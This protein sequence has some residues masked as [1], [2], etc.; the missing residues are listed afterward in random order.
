MRRR[1]LSRA[2]RCCWRSVAAIA[3]PRRRPSHAD[4]DSFPDVVDHFKYGS[5][6]TEEGVGLPYWIWQVLPTVF[7]DKLP[8]RPGT[9]YERLGFVLDRRGT[10]GRSARPTSRGP[11]RARRPQLRHLSRRHVRETPR[12]PRRIVAGMPANQ[13][14]LQGYANFLT[15]CASDPRFNYDTLMTA[16]RKENPD[17]G[18]FTRLIYRLFIVRATKNGIL[19]RAEQNAWFE[20]RPPF[21][22]G[23]VDTFNPYKVMLELPIDDVVGTV[24]LPSLWNQRMRAR[25]WLHWDGNNDLGRG[26]QQ[27]RRHRRRRDARLARPRLDAPDRELDSRSEAAAVP[28][29]ADRQGS[30][31]PT[32]AASGSRPAPAATRS[33]AR[34]S[35]R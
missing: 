18:W 22:P 35:D 28:G 15:A 34:M 33:K 29:G 27:E 5:I 7:E 20:R 31:Q 10:S 3:V 14:D 24:D 17:I 32:G 8:K 11:R 4:S 23:R 25:M 1:P 30:A 21:G 19:E 2:P 12:R 26:A 13:M 6:G 9:G 16:I